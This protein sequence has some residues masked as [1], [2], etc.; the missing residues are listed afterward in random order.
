[1]FG[2]FKQTN[3]S[4][5]F[6]VHQQLCDN[7]AVVVVVVV[8]VVAAV[9]IIIINYK[10]LPIKTVVDCVTSQLM[11]LSP[12]LTSNSTVREFPDCPEDF[13]PDVRSERVFEPGHAVHF[14]P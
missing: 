14:P 1:M 13:N 2:N 5:T 4:N 7:I 10:G 6:W 8:A 11:L 3:N 12:L 9:V